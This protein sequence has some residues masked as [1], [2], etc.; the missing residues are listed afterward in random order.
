MPEYV[1]FLQITTGRESGKVPAGNQ[2]ARIAETVNV[3]N[4]NPVVRDRDRQS[5]ALIMVI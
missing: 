3:R 5:I 1:L 2:G 4:G